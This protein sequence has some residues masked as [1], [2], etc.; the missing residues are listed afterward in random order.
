MT[1]KQKQ[2]LSRFVLMVVISLSI[3]GSLWVYISLNEY[4]ISE[5][6]GSCILKKEILSFNSKNIEIP[7]ISKTV[8]FYCIGGYS[9]VSL[10]GSVD[11]VPQIIGNHHPYPKK[12]KCLN[13]EMDEIK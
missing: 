11:F 8:I 4:Q 3:A 12:C 9:Y 5:K 13:K 6:A 10:K 1:E 7:G 2:I